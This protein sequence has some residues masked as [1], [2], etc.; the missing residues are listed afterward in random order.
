MGSSGFS[1]ALSGLVHVVTTEPHRCSRGYLVLRSVGSVIGKKPYKCH[2]ISSLSLCG[3]LLK[4]DNSLLAEA[5]DRGGPPLR[6]FIYRGTLNTQ[7]NLSWKL[8]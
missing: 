8:Y 3:L 7:P 4:C 2:N 6:P 1:R 5:V